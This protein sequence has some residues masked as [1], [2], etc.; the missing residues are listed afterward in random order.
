M[1]TKLPLRIRKAIRTR[2]AIID[3][4]TELFEKQGFAATTLNQI[5]DVADVH[6][7]T[8]LR[9]FNTKEEIALALRTH[10]LEQLRDRLLDESRNKPVIE[11]WR[12]FV[13][14]SARAIAANPD[15][16]RFNQFLLQNDKIVAQLLLIEHRYEQ[17][18]A[19]A[20]AREAGVDPATDL[21]SRMLAG[22]LVA[23]N[24]MVGNRIFKDGR[25][26]ELE[27][28]CLEV[29]DFARAKFP[30]REP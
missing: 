18:L 2:K 16:F 21:Y 1:A 6:K 15:Q 11:I 5:A 3:A 17:I 26:E 12:S 25:I 30:A 23:G 19:E 8:V 9:Y 7:Q 24:F 20:F 4:A 28:A 14:V 22:M 10:V 13:S 27:G 29:V